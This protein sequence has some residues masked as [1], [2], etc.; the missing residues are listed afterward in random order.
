MTSILPFGWKNREAGT[1]LENMVLPR[2]RKNI[3][4]HTALAAGATTVFQSMNDG[5]W[6]PQMSVPFDGQKLMALYS[7]ITKGL[8]FHHWNICLSSEHILKV[9]FFTREGE[10]HIEKLMSLNGERIQCNLGHDTFIYEGV[11]SYEDPY[12]TVWRMSFYGAELGESR[13]SKLM[14]V[15]NAYAITAPNKMPAA[16][17]FV[18]LLGMS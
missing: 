2:L 10:R 18:Q 17:K 11:R 8:A 3:K 5:S 7:Y 13:K 12:L 1:M 4:L 16:S 14:R 6:T 15:S 9:G